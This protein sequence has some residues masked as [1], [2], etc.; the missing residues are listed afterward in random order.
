M[1]VSEKTVF[2]KP[3]F[4]VLSGLFTN[5]SAAFIASAFTLLNL[6]QV[7]FLVILAVLTFNMVFATV[8]LLIAFWFEEYQIDSPPKK[9]LERGA[10]TPKLVAI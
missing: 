9:S 7:S 1:S 8:C 4:K 2:T 6:P 5:L 3:R 10:S